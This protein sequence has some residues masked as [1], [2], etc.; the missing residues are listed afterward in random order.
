MEFPGKSDNF[1]SFT[2][3][4]CS[5][6]CVE[7]TKF[8]HAPQPQGSVERPFAAQDEMDFCSRIF[9]YFVIPVRY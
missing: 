7:F 5:L 4:H 3:K 2:C 6:E 1:M 9:Y 8:L